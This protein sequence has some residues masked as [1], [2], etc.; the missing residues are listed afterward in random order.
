M[1]IDFSPLKEQVNHLALQL[2]IILIVPLV[3]GLIVKWIL[4]SIK[5]PNSVANFGA[6]LVLL[7]TFYK[8]IIIVLG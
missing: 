4:R 7:F 5:L 3:V 2:A 1:S 8:T 6:V